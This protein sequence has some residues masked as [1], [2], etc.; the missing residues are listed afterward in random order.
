MCRGT[1]LV[2]ENRSS[3]TTTH[4][5]PTA[6][7]RQK[8]RWIPYVLVAPFL[9]ALAVFILGPLLISLIN[10]LFVERLIGGVT[11]VGLE[12]YARALTD[13]N[14]WEGFGRLLL[15]GVIFTPLTIGLSLLIAVVVDSGAVRGSGFYRALYFIPYAIPGVVAT[16]MWGFLYGP[17]ISPFTDMAEA[18][19]LE[20]LN[21][22]S[23]Q[24]VLFAIGNIGIWAFV[25]YNV[26]IFY[27][28]LRAIPEEIYEAAI[29]DGAG[30]WRIGFSIKLPMIK[31][32]I[33]MVVIFSIIGTVQLLTE[34]LVLQPLQPRSIEDNFTP[35]MYAYSLAA[36]GQQLNYV[37]AISFFMGLVVVALS[38]VYS[39]FMN[40][41]EKGAS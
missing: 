24:F 38:V 31:P 14:F 19:G 17:T 21:L 36:G 40:R 16:L 30:R 12:N 8:G 27:A 33:T 37:A 34:P 26:M 32:V 3:M 39:K 20:G 15:Y 18:V 7:R 6:A 2:P 29:L 41:P 35:N 11:F 1:R 13:A 25:G 4:A 9:L 5:P 28:A 22:L 10:S 23:P